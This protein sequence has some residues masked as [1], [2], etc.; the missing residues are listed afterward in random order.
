MRIYIYIPSPC[1]ALFGHL[2]MATLDL[3]SEFSMYLNIQIRQFQ[4]FSQMTW[5]QEVAASAI[6]N[7][8]YLKLT[9]GLQQPRIHNLCLPG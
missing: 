6:E 5:V 9:T 1:L 3:I 4:F 2:K 8:A 7:W